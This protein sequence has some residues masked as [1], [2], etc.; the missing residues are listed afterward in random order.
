MS[1][2]V[3]FKPP[4]E[5]WFAFGYHVDIPG[6]LQFSDETD[7]AGMPLWERPGETRRGRYQ[8]SITCPVCDF[9]SYH[10][11]DVSE[12]YCRNCHDWTGKEKSHE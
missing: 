6:P 8:E 1:D 5:G 3:T 9:T 2:P 11:T 4:P 12:G 7:E 10:P